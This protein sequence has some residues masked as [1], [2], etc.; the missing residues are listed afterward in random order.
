MKRTN[1]VPESAAILE[2]A[3]STVDRRRSRLIVIVISGGNAY[4]DQKAM[5]N[6]HHE[7]KNTLP[8]W[9]TGLKTGIDLALRLIG[10]TSGADQST[11]MGNMVAMIAAGSSQVDGSNQSNKTLY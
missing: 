1:S 2:L 4:H 7:K 5:K 6:P 8:Y 9:L 10:L 3:T 11:E